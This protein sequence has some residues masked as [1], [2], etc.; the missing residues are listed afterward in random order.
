MDNPISNIVF[1]IFRMFMKYL[2]YFFFRPLGVQEYFLSR[3]CEYD[4]ATAD[5]ILK[6]NPDQPCE[7]SIIH[8]W[9][10]WV[11]YVLLFQVST[12]HFSYLTSNSKLVP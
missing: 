4:N 2:D 10:Q 3:G 8:S 11:P 1:L 12:F 9:Y 6:G 5:W 7:G